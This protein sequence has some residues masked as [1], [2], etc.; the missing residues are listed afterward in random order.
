MKH[1][2]EKAILI[3]KLA[4]LQVTLFILCCFFPLIVS[5]KYFESESET[6]RQAS[7]PRSGACTS[8]TYVFH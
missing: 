8:S 2:A 3:E 6:D 4:M 5:L 1:N 7:F